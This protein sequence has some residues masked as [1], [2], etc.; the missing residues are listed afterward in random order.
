M[1]VV[2]KAGR[3][4]RLDA[5]L[6]MRIDADLL[7]RLQAVC[8]ETGQKMSAAARFLLLAGLDAHESERK[9]RRP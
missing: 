4:G 3:T 2:P 7:A 9:K 8:E 1:A 5:E 6:K